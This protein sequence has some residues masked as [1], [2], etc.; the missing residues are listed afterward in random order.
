MAPAH[1]RRANRPLNT[2]KNIFLDGIDFLAVFIFFKVTKIAS[3][4]IDISNPTTPPSLL[5]IER[6]IA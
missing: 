1:V 6:R 5:G 4:R 2:Q 3:S